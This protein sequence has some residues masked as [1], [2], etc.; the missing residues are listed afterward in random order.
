MAIPLQRIGST[1]DDVLRLA[2]G[3]A[4]IARDAVQVVEH[5]G[6]GYHYVADAATAV[7]HAGRAET[8]VREAFHLPGAPASTSWQALTSDLRLGVSAIRTNRLGD[9]ASHLATA[10]DDIERPPML[11]LVGW[12]KLTEQPRVLPTGY[13]PGADRVVAT[14]AVAAAPA[15]SPIPAAAGAAAPAQ[16]SVVDSL[17]GLLGLR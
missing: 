6:G 3:E 17:L 11:R 9:A 4:R 5:S 1:F 8:L 7:E 2:A 13:A 16:G 15:A 10:A 14:P 12:H